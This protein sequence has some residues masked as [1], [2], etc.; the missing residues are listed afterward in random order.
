MGGQ[1]ADLQDGTE[2]QA[3]QKQWQDRRLQESCIKSSLPF[4]YILRN[5]C[6]HFKM[7]TCISCMLLHAFAIHNITY[8]IIPIPL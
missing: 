1:S 3:L 5:V 6:I 4:L 2:G 7:S 8:F